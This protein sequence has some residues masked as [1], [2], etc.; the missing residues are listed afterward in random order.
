MKLLASVTGHKAAERSRLIFGTWQA[1]CLCSLGPPYQS[2]ES[3][4]VS[5]SNDVEAFMYVV[6]MPM[7]GKHNGHTLI[8]STSTPE[9][10]SGKT[11]EL[12]FA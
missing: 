9:G 12:K 1:C 11:A 6:I 3:D 8:V 4:Y 2:T 5:T 7:R 10:G